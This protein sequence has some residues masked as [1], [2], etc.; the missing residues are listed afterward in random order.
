MVFPDSTQNVCHNIIGTDNIEKKKMTIMSV[1][2]LY[3]EK[4]MVR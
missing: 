1:Q 4:C 3:L 2:S